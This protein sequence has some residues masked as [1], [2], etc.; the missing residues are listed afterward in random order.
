MGQH[1]QVLLTGCLINDGPQFGLGVDQQSTAHVYQSR[2]EVARAVGV[3]MWGGELTVDQSRVTSD[4]S[5]AILAA[6]AAHVT[7]E[8]ST[9]SSAWDNLNAVGLLSLNAEADD[10][11]ICCASCGREMA[12]FLVRQGAVMYL[13]ARPEFE[14][15]CAELGVPMACDACWTQA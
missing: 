4:K 10:N 7:A 2:V 6:R 8:N 13:A 15:V 3:M 1:S 11:S 14:R 12:Q 5:A 9:I